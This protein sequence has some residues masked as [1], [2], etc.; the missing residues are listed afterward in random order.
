MSSLFFSLMYLAF[1]LFFSYNLKSQV[2]LFFRLVLVVF[3]S[4]FKEPGR[5]YFALCFY[6]MS[7]FNPSSILSFAALSFLF[8]FNFCQ[9]KMHKCDFPPQIALIL[10]ENG[11]GNWQVGF[12]L[13]LTRI[14]YIWNDHQPLH[15]ASNDFC[16]FHPVVSLFLSL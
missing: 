5:C 7:K 11:G 2:F 1:Q 16:L 9:R 15:I 6:S 13:I 12:M 14:R 8:V 3:L 10:K 4:F